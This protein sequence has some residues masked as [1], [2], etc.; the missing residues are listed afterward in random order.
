MKE[1]RSLPRHL[2]L[3]VALA[4]ALLP[5]G[6]AAANPPPL[7]HRVWLAFV[8]RDG[9]PVRPRAVQFIGCRDAACADPVLQLQ[10]G[11]CSAAD[12]L[13]GPPLLEGL[14]RVQCWGSRCLVS[15]YS[16]TAPW[17]FDQVLAQIGGTTLRSQRLH[18]EE[19]GG[20]FDLA[21]RVTVGPTGLEL[22][23]D[24]SFEMPGLSY[25]SFAAGLTITVL[26]ELAVA[27][28]W[29]VLRD[30]RQVLRILMLVPLVNLS[31]LPAVWAFFP[32]LAPLSSFDLQSFG[33]IVLVLSLLY[34]LLLV[35]VSRSQTV[36]M[37]LLSGLGSAAAIWIL[38]F[39]WDLVPPYFSYF[40]PPPRAT[41]GLPQLAILVL[42]ELYAWLVEAAV[43]MLGTRDELSW[44]RARELSLLTNA[45]SFGLGVWLMG[46]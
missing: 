6:S 31:T 22:A 9:A 23:P 10:S 7:S 13:S 17:T 16:M 30:R 29:L 11:D 2:L 12:C 39:A 25:R 20:G 19:L 18:T 33:T 35:W 1:R 44:K 28:L 24:P 37:A 21:L 34:C 38:S 26:S 46:L 45:A 15:V 36:Q 40:G 32:A 42:A 8:D 41:A 5:A 14:D 3:L 27:A 43:Y 4:L